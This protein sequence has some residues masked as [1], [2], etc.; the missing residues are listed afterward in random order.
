MEMEVP[1]G[2]VRNNPKYSTNSC[3]T[4]AIIAGNDSDPASQ[5]YKAKTLD[6]DQKNEFL[7]SGE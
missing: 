1:R 5:M 6:V 7:H 3:H 2:E 4:S